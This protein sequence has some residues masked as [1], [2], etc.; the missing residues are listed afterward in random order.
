M[1]Y[2][3]WL[4]YNGVELVNLSR[5]AQLAET[6]DIDTL[7]V[8]A[9]SVAW[10]Q[11]ELGGTNYDDITQAPWY[12]P[13]YPASLEFAGIVP[14]SFLGLGDSTV[15]SST[16]QYTTDGGKSGKSRSATLPLVA[17]VAIVAAT[18]RGAEYGKRW[19]DRMLRDAGASTFCSGADLR[20]FRWADA[21]SPIAHHRDVRLTRGSTITRKR[22]SQCSSTWLATFTMSADDPYEYGEEMSQFILL[23]DDVIGD[24]VASNGSLALIQ[25]DCAVYDYTPIYDPLFPALVAPPA[26]P[27]FFP[28]GWDI[29]PGM[30]FDRFWARLDPVEPSELNV[31][32]IFTLSTTQEA[33]FARVSVWPNASDITDQCGPLF[34]AVVSYLPAG[35]DFFIDGEQKAAYVWDGATA[36]VRR[37][38]SLIY[39]PDAKPVQWTAFNDSAGLLV[40]LD[41]FGE[42]SGGSF[43]ESGG[44]NVVAALSLVHKSD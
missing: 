19:M 35:I 9:S 24:G 12:D 23:G 39:A 21:G 6:L 44:G 34:S 32:P 25:E 10:I 37:A 38:D 17:N 29:T 43:V 26:V 13:G 7:W 22:R 2:D 11:T 18:D 30:T 8:R 14:L 1:S 33:R 20:Y 41:I 28:A 27:D 4:E 42:G 40:T 31:V 15:E 36:Y 5:T 16:V 3:G